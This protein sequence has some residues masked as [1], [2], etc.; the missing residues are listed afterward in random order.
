MFLGGQIPPIEYRD[1]WTQSFE[2]RVQAFTRRGAVYRIAYFYQRPDTSTL[3]YRVYNM[4]QVL[5][6]CAEI[7][8]SWFTEHEIDR[9][10]PLLDRCDTLVICRARYS[11]H[12]GQLLARAHSLGIDTVFDVD[13]LVFNVDYAHLLLDT[14]GHQFNA[15]TWDEWFAYIS[16]IGATMREI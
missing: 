2:K 11:Q 10:L 3:R 8:A 7:A 16:R 13:D 1:P 4:T 6:E 12:F 15:Q 5:N 9:V 14:L